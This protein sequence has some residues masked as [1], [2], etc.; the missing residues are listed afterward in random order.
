MF[1]IVR[2]PECDAS[3]PER[4]V[5]ELCHQCGTRVAAVAGEGMERMV[6]ISELA[7]LGDRIVTCHNCGTRCP[8]L[9]KPQPCF[10][11]KTHL[12]PAKRPG[13]LRRL[14]RRLR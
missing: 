3:W 4:S 8:G 12:E 14:L 11:C 2:C 9:P 5:P 13:L 10:R 6:E 1:G 7:G